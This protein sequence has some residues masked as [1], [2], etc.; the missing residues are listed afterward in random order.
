M[1]KWIF[2]IVALIATCANAGEPIPYLPDVEYFPLKDQFS[3]PFGITTGL[4]GEI[5]FTEQRGDRIGRIMPDGQIDE[6]PLREPLDPSVGPG[7]VIV[8]PD[9]N[10]WFTEFE[11]IGVGRITPDGKTIDHFPGPSFRNPIDIASGP[12]GTVW[13]TELTDFRGSEPG[14]AAGN[15]PGAVSRMTSQGVVKEFITGY[16]SF[17]ITQGPDDAMWFTSTGIARIDIAGNSQL[18]PFAGR[19]LGI[20]TG[21]DGALWFVNVPDGISDPN[22]AGGSATGLPVATWVVGRMTTDG[23]LS[24][25]FLDEPVPFFRP[26]RIIRGPEDNLWFTNFNGGIWRINVAGTLKEVLPLP[27]N[28]SAADLTA[29]ADGRIWFTQPNTNM[30]GRFDSLLFDA[31][32]PDD[33]QP[34]GLARGPDDSIWFT[35]Y[36]GGRIGRILPDN[37]YRTFNLSEGGTPTA[38][39]A[40]PDGSAWFTDTAADKIG[41]VK[42]DG[43]V[44]EIP[45]PNPPSNPQ[46]IVFGPDGNLWFTE[47]DAGAIGRVTMQGAFA[48]FPVPLPDL[49][50]TLQPHLE[51]IRSRPLNIAVGPDGNLWFTDEG[52]NKIG[53]ITTGGVI[54]EFPIPTEDSGPAGIAAGGDGN[55]YF[56]ESNSGRPARITTAGEVTELG[57]P[58]VDSF[59]NYITR[60]PDGAMW[61]SEQDTNRLGRIAPDGR[62][63]K[64]EL[65][66]IFRPDITNLGLPA[67][68]SLPT[69]IV[70]R[71]DRLFVG[72]LGQSLIAF[73]D[74]A[75]A[76]P[77]RTATSTPTRTRTPTVTSTP[78]RTGTPTATPRTP[79]ATATRTP[80][81]R[82]PTATP[83]DEGSVA[84]PTRTRTATRTR[85]TGIGDPTATATEVSIDGTPTPTE[86]PLLAT[87]TPT[88][89]DSDPTETETPAEETPEPTATETTSCA[90]DCDGNQAVSI[91][92]LVTAVNIALGSRGVEDCPNADTD[93]DEVVRVNDLVTA[94]GRALRG[95]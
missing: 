29:G 56:V 49:G 78:T 45:I 81:S 91:S 53:R 72:L 54:D 32:G 34:L 84:T 95:C 60:G 63:T 39:T 66:A 14:T 87:P 17:G 70:G 38:V 73:T 58:D 83:T 48:R 80:T 55:L 90:G 25:F 68:D 11:R 36:G 94:V 41:H 35:D 89:P 6:F 19:P 42:N 43:E 26:E 33:I 57:T 9:G 18:F 71:G 10:I 16:P 27:E 64:F 47:Y 93:G 30:I 92:E 28:E 51:V 31:V 1:A 69:G 5:W 62:I 20:T 7:F 37:Q 86:Q 74:L 82:P 46:D 24:T 21:P 61:F 67:V 40:A 8:G 23:S 52:L 79:A 44:V 2:V 59:P 76:E 22:G 88:A 13:F 75:A 12:L 50:L 85:T 4:S 77:T 3:E 15:E 65:P